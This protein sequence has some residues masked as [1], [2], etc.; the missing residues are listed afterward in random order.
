PSDCFG[1]RFPSLRYL[2]PFPVDCLKIDRTF[3][4][5]LISVPDDAAITVAVIAMAHA[6]DLKVVA[7]GVETHEHLAFLRGQGCDEVQGHLV[8][9]AVPADRFAEWLARGRPGTR[10]AR[11]AYRVSR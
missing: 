11:H 9:R 3:V 8:G 6:L 5:D 7:E 2:K 1:A 4:R 10:L